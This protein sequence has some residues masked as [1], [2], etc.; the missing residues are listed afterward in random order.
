MLR[1]FLIF[2]AILAGL[3]AL[4]DRGAAVVAGNATAAQ[5]KLHE[6]LRD[7]PSVRFRGFPFVTQAIR[8]KFRAIDVTVRDVVREGVT[9]DRID[10]H[11]EDVEVHLG[12][13]LK[14]RV[15]AVPVREGEAT[16]R[17]AY[18]DLASFL[19][20]KPGNIRLDVM[21]GKLVVR[22]T[23]GIPGAGQVE[24]EGTPSVK[25]SGTAL[26]VTVAG[27]HTVTSPN[28]LTPGLAAQA[29]TRSSFTIPLGDLP[30]G[31]EIESA[32]LTDEAFV[33]TASARGL[34]VDV[35]R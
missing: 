11:L 13:A 8:G 18:G 31:I 33:V 2:L 28:R 20:R 17:L 12:Q 34:V 14:G 7:D 4:A 1:R 16:V 9:I 26:R 15:S 23:F 35:G 21:G 6:G 19:G 25:V 3:A 32:R 5:I 30:F 27:M 22:S 24:V 10:A 29:G